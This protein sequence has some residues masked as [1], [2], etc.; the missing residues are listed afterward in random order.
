MVKK[1]PAAATKASQP[2]AIHEMMLL[3]GAEISSWTFPSA[4][5]G[6][7]LT[8]VLTSSDILIYCSEF[9]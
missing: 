4:A 1:P 6:L 5:G 8:L 2:T 7:I 9:F 3:R